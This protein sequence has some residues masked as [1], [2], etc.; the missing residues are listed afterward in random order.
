MVRIY[1]LCFK[2]LVIKRHQLLSLIRPFG[3]VLPSEYF[4]SF[5]NLLIRLMLLIYNH[6]F[7]IMYS[8]IQFLFVT[9]LLITYLKSGINITCNIIYLFSF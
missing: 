7:Y 3:S 9:V 2:K 4:Y 5:F 8:H 1:F 6:Y